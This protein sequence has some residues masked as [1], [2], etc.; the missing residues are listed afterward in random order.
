MKFVLLVALCGGMPAAGQTFPHALSD[1]LSLTSAHT[2]AINKLNLE[3]WQFEGQKNSRIADVMT[4]IASVTAADPLDSLALGIRYAEVE[5]IRRDLRDKQSQLR[6]NLVAVLTAS[7]QVRLADAQALLP[8]A[9]EA[10]CSNLLTGS[11]FPASN[12]AISIS[13][14]TAVFISSAAIFSVPFPIYDPSVFPP[15]CPG[16]PVSASLR[17]YVA[18][19]DAQVDAINR[20]NNAYRQF[21]SQKQARIFDVQADIAQLTSA[22]PLDPAALGLRY[23]EIEAIYRDL[24]D[25][26]A[27]LRTD[28]ANLLTLPQKG[29]LKTA[30]DASS[31]LSNVISQ[32]QCENLLAIPSTPWFDSVSFATITRLPFPELVRNSPVR[33][34][35][36]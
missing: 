19:T 25:K 11:T 29:A 23:A 4:D 24:R 34:C 17:Q 31:Q 15:G 7:Q 8:R 5:S 35:G 36:Q 10:L 27:G 22:E 13:S 32:A 12:S 1:Y 26:L 14:S 2:E 18:L 16:T 21:Y 20:L 28:L 9:V 33:Y 6:A 3:Y 30:Q